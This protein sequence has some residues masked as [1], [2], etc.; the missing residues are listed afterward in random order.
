MLYGGCSYGQLR[1]KVTFVINAFEMRSKCIQD[2]S[3]ALQYGCNA[4][5]GCV[6]FSMS[7]THPRHDRERKEEP[8]SPTNSLR[9]EV[10]EPSSCFRLILLLKQHAEIEICKQ[11]VHQ[12]WVNKHNDK[13][14]VFTARG[15]AFKQL[16][17]FSELIIHTFRLLTSL[18][19]TASCLCTEL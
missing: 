14:C 9:I 7:Q 10:I 4:N 12:N 13:I 16:L 8:W 1:Y 5:N 19:I 18:Y 3:N 17:Y 2:E 6:L 15:Q 11:Y